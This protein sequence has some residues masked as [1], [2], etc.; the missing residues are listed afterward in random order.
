VSRAE[1]HT[2]TRRR[3]LA[4]LVPSVLGL[5]LAAVLT[6]CGAGQITQTDTQTASINGANGTVGSMAVRNVQLAF[7]SDQQGTYAPGSSARVIVTIVNT[8]LTAD[9]LVKI[10]SPAATSV[11]IDGS[12]TG[13]KT[14]PGGFAVSSGQDLDDSTAGPSSASVPVTTIPTTTQPPAP[15]TTPQSGT[16]AS[17]SVVPGAPSGG[18]VPPSPGTPTSTA[19]TLPGKVTIELVGI[20]SLN[21]A[22]LRAGLTIPITFY[23]ANAGQVTLAQVPIGAP[24]DASS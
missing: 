9:Q 21:G 18:T 16:G 3:V 2:T 1:H 6:G 11:T 14:I 22:S 7:P 8:G 19:P 13:S 23:F 20:R 24:A 17:G 5:G 10:T 15:T 4:G 12:A